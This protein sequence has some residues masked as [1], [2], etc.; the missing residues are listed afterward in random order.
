MS[1]GVTLNMP[2]SL[3]TKFI[4]TLGP[5]SSSYDTMRALAAAGASIFRAN[6]AHMDYEMFQRW[7]QW[8][9]EI[10]SD[11]GTSVKLQADIQGPNIRLGDLGPDKFFLKANQEYVFATK[12]GDCAEGEIPINDYMIHNF[13]QPGQ[14]V[15]FSSGTI[16]GEVIAVD[17]NRIRVKMINSGNIATHKALNFPETELDSA[18]TDKD[19]RDI[20]FVLGCNVDWIA[21]SFVTGRKEL[22]Y[23][24][25]KIGNRPIYLMAKI[26]RQGALSNLDEIVKGSDAIMIAR[27][28]LGVEVPM[29][30]V[31]I[32]QRDVIRFGH[33]EKK[34]VVVAT[35]MLLSMTESSRPTRA[36]VT[37]VANAVF[38]RADAVMLS[39]ESA[40][41]IDPVNALSTMVKIVSRAEKY[42]YGQDN[43]FHRYW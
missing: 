8:I 29:E 9:Y 40:Q 18:L 3:H 14:P 12:G 4:V 11:L 10:N 5:A 34:P 43:Y 7:R 13:V 27:G 19:W 42:M 26:E 2:E 41:G 28:D 37:D 38:E 1:R 25:E 35:Q 36:E 24:R 15:A 23:V 6:F 30:D 20:D 17:G 39:E 21:L 31:P 32:I 33:H 16:E 22:D